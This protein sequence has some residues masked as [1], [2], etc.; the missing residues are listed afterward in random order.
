MSKFTG[1]INILNQCC[2]RIPTQLLIAH[3]LYYSQ[4]QLPTADVRAWTIAPIAW[5][6]DPPSNSIRGTEIEVKIVA[7]H[8][9]GQVQRTLFEQ[10]HKQLRTVL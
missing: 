7:L 9:D 6:S 5:K 4:F 10:S 8:R 1:E 3:R 2:A